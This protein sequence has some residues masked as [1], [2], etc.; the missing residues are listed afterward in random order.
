M[1]KTT[2]VSSPE[3]LANAL[4]SIALQIHQAITLEDLVYTTVEQIRQL[5]ETDRVLLLSNQ[6]I[7][8]ASMAQEWEINCET[9]KFATSYSQYQ[10]VTIVDLERNCPSPSHKKLLY[11]LQVQ[12]ELVVPITLPCLPTQPWGLIIIHHCHSS[13]SWS[14]P[15]IEAVQQLVQ[16]TAVAIERIQ[17]SQDLQVQLEV[18]QQLQQQLEEELEQEK[19]HRNQVQTVFQVLRIITSAINLDFPIERIIKL[20]LEAIH[21]FF[22]CFDVHYG[23]VDIEGNYTIIK[24]I[25]NSG[26]SG[27]SNPIDLN[28]FSTYLHFLRRGEPIIIEDVNQE[29]EFVPLAAWLSAK[30]W[31]A[32]PLRLE[33]E[34]I[35]VISLQAAQT[36]T[37]SEYEV[38]M[39]IEISSHLASAFWETQKKE[40][41]QRTEIAL[42]QAKDQLQA[43][44]DAVPGFISWMSSDGRYLGVNR[45]LAE[46]FNFAPQ[47]FIGQEVGFLRDSTQFS[48]LMQSFLASAQTATSQVISAQSRDCVR[49]YLIA[50]KKYQQGKAAV[51][52]GIDI[53]DRKKVEEERDRAF[54]QI[55][56]HNQNLETEVSKRT[57]ELSTELLERK[58]AE[59]ALSKSE[60]RYRT[61][62]K[63]IPDGAVVLFD[64]DLRHTF[65][66][67]A[68]LSDLGF[69]R[70]FVENKT[71][72]ELFPEAICQLLEPNYR[73]ALAGQASTFELSYQHR[74]YL[75]KT[76]PL[77]NSQGTTFAGMSLIQD[78]T[79]QKQAEAK[80]TN[81]LMEKETLIKE[82]HHRV[83][84]NLQIISSL[85]RLQSR[86]LQDPQ[87]MELFNDSQNRV[88]AMALVHEQLYQ[89]PNLAQIDF[90][91]YIRTLVNNLF[92]SYGTHRH[93]ISLQLAIEP[94]PL[95]ID[96][97]ITCG[98][99]INELI[100]NCLKYAFPHQSEGKILISLKL[101]KLGQLQLIVKDN[102]VG[103][104]KNF[105]F[106][107]TNSLGL[108][109]V[110]RLTK[111]LGGHIELN[112]TQGTEFK[113]QFRA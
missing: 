20:T 94:V 112:C 7:C 103:L 81:S 1:V 31:L 18:Q 63:N 22:P 79:E 53:T 106:R 24:A 43:V 83:K 107:T 28:V 75:M 90:P 93:D 32:V 17:K 46:S 3:Q 8:G 34:I 27:H 2:D 48:D 110:C 108:Q 71:I 9:G 33:H 60:E 100:S 47:A 67:G 57:L 39:L 98:L 86:H 23:K 97:A 30:A 58:K 5:L 19:W 92:R 40:S 52:V 68:G 76:L 25:S 64:H 29:P 44:L 35:G 66:D 102:G 37:W 109:L 26:S 21:E 54:A 51:A 50:A 104:P 113:I 38:G 111:Q 6:R 41:H 61:L 12:A 49:Y 59:A 85:L 96:K 36:H 89:S 69:F 77:K 105:N 99:I 101:D 11:K 65:A 56:Q 13:R 88:R 10:G 87:V 78:I 55:A 80:I 95:E 82:I 15:I 72:W 42:Q 16:T 45:H 91:E 70:D 14:E 4:I 84:N 62:I 74:Y 73:E